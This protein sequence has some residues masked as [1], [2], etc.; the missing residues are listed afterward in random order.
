ML[1][2]QSLV[3]DAEE[4]AQVLG[5]KSLGDFLGVSKQGPC[6]TATPEDGDKRRLVQ[7]ELAYEATGC[8]FAIEKK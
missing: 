5:L 3:G 1:R 4:F 2:T 6:L 8:C 7:L